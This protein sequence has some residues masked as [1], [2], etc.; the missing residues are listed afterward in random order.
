MYNQ[1]DQKFSILPRLGSFWYRTIEDSATFTP[2][3]ITH[4]PSL[5]D[6]DCQVGQIINKALGRSRVNKRNFVIKFSDSDIDGAKLYVPEN[7]LITS[8]YADD[9]SVLCRNF[10]FTSAYGSVTFFKDPRSAFPNLRI[11]VRSAIERKR[12][13]LCYPLG[14]QDVYG[15]V[16]FI[17]DYCRNNQSSWQFYR[18]A[19]QA[20]GFQVVRQDCIVDHVIN[21]AQQIKDAHTQN[22]SYIVSTGE[23]YD[24]WYPH[25]ALQEGDRLTRGDIIG[26]IIQSKLPAGEPSQL[27]GDELFYM[28]LPDDPDSYAMA[29]SG[30]I[31]GQMCPVPGIIVQNED[32]VQIYDHLDG[33]FRPMY[34][35][36]D[37][38][39]QKY[40]NYL[41]QIGQAI[42]EDPDLYDQ[43]P[44]TH[45]RNVAAHGRCIIVVVSTQLPR[46]IRKKIYSYIKTNAPIG[47]VLLYG[48]E[49]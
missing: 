44:L 34:Q 41:D 23:R 3:K 38:I 49:S 48:V 28:I 26:G 12:N 18:A 39:L 47:S 14:V 4:V 21:D 10:N 45:F 15:D 43:N 37:D 27:S 36:S 25:T 13:I 19:A 46:D 2:N 31:L 42:Q 30:A 5:F 40:H 22:V 32:A 7:I 29:L 9:G 11:N 1:V 35:A 6:T 24:A 17:V 16:S 20:A 33:K 8:I